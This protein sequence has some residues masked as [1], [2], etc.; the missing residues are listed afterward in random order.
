MSVE[1]FPTSAPARKP[2][3]R[4]LA[5]AKLDALL[6]EQVPF[7]KLPQELPRLFAPGAPGVGALVR[8]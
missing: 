8:Y 5:D 2:A 7:E 4:L 6:G 3:V 1:P